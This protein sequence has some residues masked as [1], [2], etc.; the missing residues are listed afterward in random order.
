MYMSETYVH[1]RKSRK[2]PKIRKI[3][4][5][6]YVLPIV[7]KVKPSKALILGVRRAAGEIFIFSCHKNDF[8]AILL[9]NQIILINGVVLLLFSN[10]Q[11]I[12]CAQR[13]L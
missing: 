8:E 9:D 4:S 3:F 12:N 6:T 10:L 13:Q 5:F 7:E 1:Q 2:A 11:I